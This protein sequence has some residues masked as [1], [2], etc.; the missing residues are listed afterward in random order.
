MLPESIMR[1]YLLEID[2]KIVEAGKIMSLEDLSDDEKD[3]E[4]SDTIYEERFHCGVCVT[5]TVM[6]TVYPAISAYYD[7]LEA[8]YNER[9]TA[10]E[11]AWKFIH[12]TISS[13]DNDKKME[14]LS[15]MA[16]MRA[17]I[18]GPAIEST[19]GQ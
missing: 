11:E 10:L 5:R 18:D 16:K 9:D 15:L 14:A 1:K 7:F 2:D 13:L 6:E 3:G 17:I 4:D 8:S 12:S 19:D